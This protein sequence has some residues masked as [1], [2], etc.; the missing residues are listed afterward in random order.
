MF[1]VV[2]R[3]Y[4]WLLRYSSANIGFLVRIRV[5]SSLM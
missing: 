2:K 4:M 1:L 3:C 5:I